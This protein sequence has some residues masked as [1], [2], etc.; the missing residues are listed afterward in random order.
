MTMLGQLMYS[1]DWA[2]FSGISHY[3]LKLKELPNGTYL[4]NVENEIIKIQK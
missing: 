3:L 1:D 2:V 4:L